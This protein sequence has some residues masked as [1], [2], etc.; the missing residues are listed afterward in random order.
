MP[1]TSA[2]SSSSSLNKAVMKFKITE[3]IFM[4]GLVAHR[5]SQFV[6]A[7]GK[8][9]CANLFRQFARDGDA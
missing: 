6:G 2:I 3:W 9:A 8:F 7:L 4:A 1:S 5:R